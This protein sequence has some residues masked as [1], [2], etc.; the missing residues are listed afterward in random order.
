MMVDGAIG[1]QLD[2]IMM[3]VVVS[4]SSSANG[5]GTASFVDTL[6]VFVSSSVSVESLE[7]VV[8]FPFVDSLGSVSIETDF[9]V[10]LSANGEGTAEGTASFFDKL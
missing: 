3:L 8:V 2:V 4:N 6:L 10:L 1:I 7:R 5:E 9:L